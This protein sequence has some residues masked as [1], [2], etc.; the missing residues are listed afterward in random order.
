MEAHAFGAKLRIDDEDGLTLRDGI[1]GALR[2]ARAAV[3]TLIGNHRSHLIGP[4]GCKGI[5]RGVKPE[6]S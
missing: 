3:D 6:Q 1:V 4:P 5:V 2:F